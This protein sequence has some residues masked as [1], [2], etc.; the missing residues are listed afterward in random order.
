MGSNIVVVWGSGSGI[1]TSN[2]GWGIIDVDTLAGAGISQLYSDDGIRIYPNPAF[3]SLLVEY[4]AAKTHI[5]GVRIYDLL[6]NILPLN[7]ISH[8]TFS[9]KIFLDISTLPSGIYILEMTNNSGQ[10]YRAKFVK[11]SL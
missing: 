4:T 7:V 3:N 8:G 1:A 11:S 5:E 9:E 6:G 10:R 2:Q